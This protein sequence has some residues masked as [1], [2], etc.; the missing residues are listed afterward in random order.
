MKYNEIC[1]TKKL[2]CNSRSRKIYFNPII[3]TKACNYIWNWELTH[4]LG[5]GAAEVWRCVIG[6]SPTVRENVLLLSS[7]V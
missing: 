3:I 4:I 5:S 7:G 1:M 2:V 6:Q